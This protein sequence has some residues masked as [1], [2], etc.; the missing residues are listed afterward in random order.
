MGKFQ[1][2]FSPFGLP[3]LCHFSAINMPFLLFTDGEK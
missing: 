2:F 1:C 3:M